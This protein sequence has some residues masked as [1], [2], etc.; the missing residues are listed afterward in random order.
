YTLAH[1]RGKLHITVRDLRSALAYLMTS[2]RSCGEIRDLYAEGEPTEILSG[3]YFQSWAGP[4]GGQDRLLALL[5]ESDV[6]GDH[7]PALDRALDFVGPG[8]GSARM[9]L[10][11]RGDYD[12]QLLQRQ[13]DLLPRGDGVA[14]AAVPVHREY[15]AAAR[16]RFFFESADGDRWRRLLAHRSATEFLDEL[17]RPDPSRAAARRV[18]ESINRS[19]GLSEPRKLGASMA[20]AVRQVRGGSIRSY[21]V[22]RAEDFTL[23]AA[24][25]RPSPY[26]ESGADHLVLRYRDP[27]A[28]DTAAT[29]IA[30]RLDLYELL[31]R[32]G[33]GG[34]PSAAD[35]QGQHLSLAVFKN[36]LTSA[37]Y[38]AVLLTVT[39][40]DL[41]RIER[42]VD[43]TLTLARQEA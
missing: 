28:P 7:D 4:D 27:D 9:I 20:L 39:G 32:L 8:A 16:R 13:F 11:G 25:P 17:R 33:R 34:R 38:Q 31:W 35:L 6:R 29:E 10:D 40:H 18:I 41:H 24:G 42:S 37:P 12:Q 3:F 26:I 19:E 22:F 5:R 21:R 43:G 36:V 30:I 23:E 2:G 15:T 14:P 1:L